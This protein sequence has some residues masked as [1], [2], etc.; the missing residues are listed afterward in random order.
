[1]FWF[2]TCGVT[3]TWRHLKQRDSV[4]AGRWLGHLGHPAGSPRHCNRGHHEI[5]NTNSN[6][7]HFLLMTK[8]CLNVRQKLNFHNFHSLIHSLSLD[9]LNNFC[10]LRSKETVYSRKL[11]YF[12][13][14]SSAAASPYP[15]ILEFIELVP[16]KKLKMYFYSCHYLKAAI[17]SKL[18]M[19]LFQSHWLG[20][21]GT[22]PITSIVVESVPENS[23][24]SKT[25]NC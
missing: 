20:C 4:M 6:L 13:G 8:Q 19:N 24:L 23:F 11:Q 1:M 14:T 10:F 3:R 22:T 7:V 25:S 9:M 2:A 15:V 17:K 16:S 12:F 21:W 18:S 5:A